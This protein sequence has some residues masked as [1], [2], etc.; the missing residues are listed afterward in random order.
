[1]DPTKLSKYIISFSLV[2]LTHQ[3]S[4]SYQVPMSVTATTSRTRTALTSVGEVAMFHFFL[5]MNKKLILPS[6]FLLAILLLSSK[7]KKIVVPNIVR[8]CISPCYFQHGDVLTKHGPYF[9]KV[10]GH[11][12]ES[13]RVSPHFFSP[14]KYQMLLYSTR[15]YPSMCTSNTYTAWPTFLI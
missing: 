2:H 7:D 9:F 4:H 5:R 8:S 15:F 3:L 6:K 12:M 10:W 11:T 13:Y 14:T 1:M